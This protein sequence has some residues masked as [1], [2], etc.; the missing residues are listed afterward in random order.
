MNQYKSVKRLVPNLSQKINLYHA[1]KN[2]NMINKMNIF[3]L[4]GNPVEYTQKAQALVNQHRKKTTYKEV[5]PEERQTSQRR[6]PDYRAGKVS[7]HNRALHQR[8]LE[9]Q[10][11]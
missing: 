5:Y 7:P 10:R 4:D 8:R 11:E 3:E 6:I 2:Q 1:N 9:H